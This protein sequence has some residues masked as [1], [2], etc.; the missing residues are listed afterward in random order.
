MS[1]DL[2]RR[3]A[4]KLREHAAT[5]RGD[6]PWL[7]AGEMVM[8]GEAEDSRYIAEVY[9]LADK[10]PNAEYIALM[11]PPVALALADLLD[12]CAGVMDVQG[13]RTP[14]GGW[15]SELP[16]WAQP[17]LFAVAREV[18]RDRDGGAS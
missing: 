16:V 11:H 17:D 3:A 14:E 9:G 15:T 8:C 2:L 13:Q 12:R 5:A 10:W 4:R 18:L 7:A 6:N 1:A